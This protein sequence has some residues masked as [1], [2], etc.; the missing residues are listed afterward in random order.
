MLEHTIFY[1][2]QFSHQSVCFRDN[3][4]KTIKREKWKKHLPTIQG[5]ISDPMNMFLVY[6]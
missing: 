2:V 1:L 6:G 5:L 4:N 3:F